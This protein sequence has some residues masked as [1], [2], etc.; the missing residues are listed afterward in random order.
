[1]TLPNKILL[2]IAGLIPAAVSAQ[3]RPS[4]PPVQFRVVLHDPARGVADLHYADESGE[5]SELNLRPKA[6]SEALFSHPVDGRL[7]FFH[8]AAVDPKKPGPAL[9]ASAKLPAG[10]RRV[11][12]ILLPA[13]KERKLRYGMLILD[14]S[15]KGFPH[16]ESRVVPLLDADLGIQ[17]GEYRLPIRAGEITRVPPVKRVD[18]YHMAQTNFYY[19]KGDEWTVFTERQLQYLDTCRRLFIVHQSAG[20][21]APTV[22]TILDV[23]PVPAP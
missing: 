1:M 13:P 11:M 7:Q 17:A 4:E 23:A 20:A 3:S 10:A 6:L 2:L 19:R 14:D 16:G 15:E 12:V 8:E 18:D 5:I 9:A 22:S 21:A